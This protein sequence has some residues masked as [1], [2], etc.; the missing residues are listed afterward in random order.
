M[1]IREPMIPRTSSPPYQSPSSHRAVPAGPG[2]LTVLQLVL[3]LGPGGTE[4]LVVE[5]V[6]RLPSTFRSI[7]C[8]LDLPGAWG[9]VLKDQGV[10]VLSLARRN[11][12]RPSLAHKIA[13][14]AREHEVGVIHCHHYSPYIYGQLANRLLTDVRLVFTEHG[15]LSDG[16]ASRKRRLANHLFARLPASVFTVSEDLKRHLAAEGFSTN[17]IGVIH[18]GI[19]PGTPGPPELRARMRRSLGVDDRFVVGTIGR[20]DPVKDLHVL[21]DGFAAFHASCP[22]SSLIVVGDGED[23]EALAAHAA[24][25]ALSDSVLLLGHREDA[26]DLLCAFDV[27]AGTSIFEGIS[28]TILEAMAAELPVIATAVGGTPEIVVDGVTG[29]LI[30]P[31]RP[32]CVVA[33]LRRLAGAPELVSAWGQAGRQRVLSQFTIDAMVRRYARI[34]RAEEM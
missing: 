34:Y 11:G 5:I 32:D 10:P 13:A 19:D 17:R 23:R 15:R 1:A 33:A 4:R 30:P 26:R 24:R 25:L 3:S 8:C 14:V 21:L 2:Q 18:N 9:E 12:F 7:V 28:L 20:L 6:R 16:P 29:V 31:R 22:L 27:Y